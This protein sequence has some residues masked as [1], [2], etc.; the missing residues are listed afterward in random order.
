MPTSKPLKGKK[1]L[2]AITGSIAAYKAPL[3]VRSL[4]QAGAEVQVLLSHSAAALVAPLTLSTL[5]NRPVLQ[6][7]IS[8]S[9]TWHNHVALGYWADLLIIAPLSAHSLAKM[10]HGICDNIIDAVYLSAKCP[11]M[12]APA[13]DSDMW[14]HAAVARNI[15]A[16]RQDGVHVLPV[17]VGELASGLNGP[18][19]MLEPAELQQHVLDFFEKKEKLSYS[20]KKALVTAGPTYEPLDPVRFIGNNSSGRMGLAICKSLLALGFE[21]QLVAGPGV[22]PYSHKNLQRIDVQT[23]E[24]MMAACTAHFAQVQLAVMAAA[25]AD[26]R[27]ASV[28][29]Q[30]IKKT[31][32]E[33]EPSIT[34]IRNPD[35]LA[36]LAAAKKPGQT[37]IGFALET[38]RGLQH[39]MDKLQRKNADFIALNMLTPQNP[40]FGAENNTITLIGAGGYVEELGTMPKEILADRLI[41]RILALKPI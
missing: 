26:Y 20:G 24:E 1:I 37:I 15:T 12:V 22:A 9:D 8:D 36:T 7:L 25:V 33:D 19:R 32:Q 30:K 41:H 17:G 10:A 35:I 2:L 27:P 23:A 38:E 4:V 6:S 11:V 16:L 28:A 3:L 34:L 31:E 39:A 21:L 29:Q 18:G 5:S 13:M 14:A 40:V